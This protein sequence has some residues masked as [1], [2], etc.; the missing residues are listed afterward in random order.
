MIRRMNTENIHSTTNQDHV[1]IE[2]VDSDDIQIRDNLIDIE[3]TNTTGRQTYYRLA[4]RFMCNVMFITIAML[5]FTGI[6]V[7]IGL[8]ISAMRH[9][10]DIF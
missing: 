9:Q 10:H 1:E 4:G 5:L 7:V 2:M 6:G 8:V 3:S